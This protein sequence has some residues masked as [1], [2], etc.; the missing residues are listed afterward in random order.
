LPDQTSTCSNSIRLESHP[1]WVL[2]DTS[3][4]SS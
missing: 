2:P 4:Q 3:Q 1:L